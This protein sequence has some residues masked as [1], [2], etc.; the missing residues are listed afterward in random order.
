[1]DLCAALAATP[2]ATVTV[3]APADPVLLDR[4]L[5]DELAAAVD[6]AL[7]NVRRHAGDGARAWVLVDD[8]GEEVLLTV[9]DNGVG[10]PQERMDEAGATWP[11]RGVLIHP[12]ADR[13]S[14]GKARYLFGRRGDHP[15]DV[16]PEEGDE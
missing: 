15:G 1:M 3:V 5:A 4:G 9:R 13:G 2:R 6:A 8:L 11:A 14:R 12:R 7:D 16:G 10:V